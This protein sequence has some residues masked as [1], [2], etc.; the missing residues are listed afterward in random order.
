MIESMPGFGP[1]LGA[2][3]LA[4]VGGDF[5]VFVTADRLAAVSGLAPVA[6]DSGRVRG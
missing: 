2:E 6:R 5:A 3:F 4:A 1:L